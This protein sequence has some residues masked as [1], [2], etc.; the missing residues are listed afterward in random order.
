MATPRDAST[1]DA[2]SSGTAA[3]GTAAAGTAGRTVKAPDERRGEIV[4]AA[5]ELFAEQGINKTSIS[6]VAARVGVTRGLV[7]HYVADKDSLV[8]AVLAEYIAELVDGIRVWDAARETGNIEQALTDCIALFRSLAGPGGGVPRIDDTRLYHRF[9]DR[10]VEAVVD[11][12][13]STTVE[14]YARRHRI[15]IDNVYETFSVLVYGLVGLIRAVPTIDDDRL[16]SIVR[17]TLRLGQG[18]GSDPR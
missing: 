16:V 11:C 5:R 8:D 2:A 6:D 18:A 15:E 3:A 13:R 10:A 4:A 7:Y 1:P 12:F 9:L 14:A 17:Q